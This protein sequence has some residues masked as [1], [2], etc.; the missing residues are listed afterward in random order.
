MKKNQA[1]SSNELQKEKGKKKEDKNQKS[2]KQEKKETIEE[3]K[4]PKQIDQINITDLEK[5]N[6]LRKEKYF[7]NIEYKLKLVGKSDER[8]EELRTQMIFRLEEG[9]GECIYVIGVEDDGT[10]L[11]IS[12]EEMR[13]SL[14]TLEIIASKLEVEL[15]IFYWGQGKKEGRILCQVSGTKKMEEKMKYFPK[16]VIKIGIL[17]EGDTG[18]ST[19]V[20][21]SS[22]NTF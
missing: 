3:F 20:R 1:Q 8:I 13:E 16:K 9:N 6:Q 11:G 18:K 4:L 19:L 10:P 22:N 2:K 17:G 12:E 15:N 21:N 7:G 5:T 14:K